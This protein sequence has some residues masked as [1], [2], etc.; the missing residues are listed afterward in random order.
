MTNTITIRNAGGTWAVR[1]GGAVIGESDAALELLE[2]DY[3]PVV[4]IPRKDIAMAFLDQSDQ[5]THCPHKGDATY[6]NIV[7]KSTTLENAAWSYEA[8]SEAA[9]QIKDYVAFY[10]GSGVAVENL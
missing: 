8:P 9:A 2:G 7:T 6:F 5:S 4:Y 3:A 10:T 1:A